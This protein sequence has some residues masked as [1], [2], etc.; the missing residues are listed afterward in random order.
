MYW[1]IDWLIDWLKFGAD[2]CS[3]DAPRGGEIYVPFYNYFCFYIP[4]HACSLYTLTDFNAKD[5]DWLKKVP[6]KKALFDIFTFWGSFSPQTPN[7]SLPVGKSHA[8]RKCRITSNPFELGQ[9]LPLT[10]NKKSWSIF[11]N[12]SWKIAWSAPWRRTDY[13]VISGWQ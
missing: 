1:L 7:I 10:T 13:D 12:P 5:A 11:Q 4:W 3:G 6:F 8:R 9:K 2:R